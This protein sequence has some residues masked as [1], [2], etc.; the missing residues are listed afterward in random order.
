MAETVLFRCHVGHADSCAG[1]TVE[2]ERIKEDEYM[3]VGEGE[4][5]LCP[6]KIHRHSSCCRSSVAIV[7]ACRSLVMVTCGGYGIEV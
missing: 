5:E 7:I 2:V 3:H 6:Q 4:K 1:N